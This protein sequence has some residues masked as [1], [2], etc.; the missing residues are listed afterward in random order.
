MA[1]EIY[2][3]FLGL[4]SD[5]NPLGKVSE[6]RARVSQLLNTVMS[7]T[8][9]SGQYNWLIIHDPL[10]MTRPD[11]DRIYKAT[12]TLREKRDIGLVITSGGG[13]I[14]PA[15]LISKLCREV[16]FN[17]FVTVVPRRAKSGATLI[18][19][20]A[21]EIHMGQLSEL[22]PIDP[23]LDKLPALGLKNAVEH[24]AELVTQY[25]KAAEM[26]SKYLTS[27]L[28]LENLGY[29]ERVAE[30]AAQYAERLLGRRISPLKSKPE[31]VAQHL[32]YGYKDHGFVID[33]MEAES[34]FGSAM[35]KGGTA[36]YELG[37]RI[38][39]WLSMIERACDTFGYSFYFYGVA[40][41][42]ANFVKKK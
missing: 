3:E 28:D 6:L 9:A 19:C 11:A 17:K 31:E 30:S 16:T 7:A 41:S 40:D 8:V 22:G 27:S 29:Y 12:T 24:L 36:E 4:I 38:Y 34:I 1:P 14:E 2:A 21:D 35:V 18:C 23:Q 5:E 20:G 26:F 13:Q 10:T 25:P 33:R 32:V 37:N 39:E 15:Y 42:D